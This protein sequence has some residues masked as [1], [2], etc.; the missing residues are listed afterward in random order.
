MWEH[1]RFYGQRSINKRLGEAG[2]D[3]QTGIQSGFIFKLLQCSE[4]LGS[5]REHAESCILRTVLYKSNLKLFF[6]RESDLTYKRHLHC[7]YI[8]LYGIM[9]IKNINLTSN[10]DTKNALAAPQN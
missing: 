5:S 1:Y 6:L 2:G 9:I 8:N 4:I 10:Y 7:K 3:R